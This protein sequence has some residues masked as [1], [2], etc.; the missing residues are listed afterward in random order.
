MLETHALR[1][2]SVGPIDLILNAGSCLAIE[3]KSGSG[4]SVL[5]RMIA[6][7]DP[8]D[9]EMTLDGKACSS[10][11]AP[12]W[13]R[14]V[15]YVPAESGWWADEVHAHFSSGTDFAAL[16]PALG[17]PVDAASWPVSR[18]STGERQRLSLLRA[19]SPDTR[20][21][22]LDEPTSGLDVESVSL[23]EA[24]MRDRLAKG[25]AILMVTHD[26][27]QAERMAGRRLTLSD[28][29]LESP[30]R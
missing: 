4:K 18:L 8:H 24:L 25:I 13:R 27:D 16:L 17:I 11:P 19:L 15:T 10:M 2:L 30:Q 12:A 14:Q 28:G 5:L 9:G 1:R 22:L 26:P 6:D 29:R 23:V 20:V 3:G 21:L 7:L